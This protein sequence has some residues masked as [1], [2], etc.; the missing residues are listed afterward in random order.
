MREKAPVERGA[1]RMLVGRQI[2]Q[3]LVLLEE[4]DDI[5]GP[6]T[7]KAGQC[8][9]ADAVSTGQRDVA[10]V[11]IPGAGNVFA[12]FCTSFRRAAQ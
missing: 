2:D 7:Q 5:D 1:N 10:R 12:A 9:S 4:N 11:D 8:G 6:D 3:T